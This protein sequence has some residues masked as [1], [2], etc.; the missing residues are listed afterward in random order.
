MVVLLWKVLGSCE[1]GSCEDAFM[2]VVTVS[3]LASLKK[4]QVIIAFFLALFPMRLC[5][6]H[7]S[8]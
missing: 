8:L 7:I 6:F 1:D 4:E 3:Y 2:L 5:L